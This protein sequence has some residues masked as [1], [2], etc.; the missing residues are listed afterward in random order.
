[1]NITPTVYTLSIGINYSP[2]SGFPTPTV[3]NLGP[4]CGNDADL[5]EKRIQSLFNVEKSVKLRNEQATKVNIQNALI[6]LKNDANQGVYSL[7]FFYYSGHGHYKPDTNSDEINDTN[8]EVII[9]FDF[10]N[11]N[12]STSIDDD[13]IRT[14]FTSQLSNNVC[15]FVFM[16][17]CHSGTIFDL[18]KSY[19]MKRTFTSS[20]AYTT[21]LYQYTNSNYANLNCNVFCISSS[22]DS[23]FSSVLPSRVPFSTQLGSVNQGGNVIIYNSTLN[24]YFAGGQDKPFAFS[25][26]SGKTWTTRVFSNMN[27]V[28]TI[29]TTGEVD[30]LLL[31][32]G[33]SGRYGFS[34]DNGN[35]FT[36]PTLSN[37]PLT[38]RCSLA[39]SNNRFFVGG[40]GRISFR[41]TAGV[42]TGHTSYFT[43]CSGMCFF[44]NNTRI[45]AVG[46]G[47]TVI[48]TN[49][50]DNGNG[51]KSTGSIAI[52]DL[53]NID[54]PTLQ[55]YSITN[56]NNFPYYVSSLYGVTSIGT[57]SLI[58]VGDTTSTP[59]KGIVIISTDDGESWNKCAEFTSFLPT[60]AH[61]TNNKC[62]I[63]GIGGLA[64]NTNVGNYYSWTFVNHTGYN[65]NCIANNLIVGRHPESKNTVWDLNIDGSL[66]PHGNS[67]LTEALFKE[68]PNIW[69]EN[70]Y[71]NQL[72]NQLTTFT[73]LLQTNMDGIDL[74]MN[75]ARDAIFVNLTESQ[76]IER[77]KS[78]DQT[79]VVSA[80]FTD[81]QLIQEFLDYFD[82]SIRT[83]F[84]GDSGLSKGLT[85]TPP[86]TFAPENNNSS[87]AP[88]VK[89][90]VPTKIDAMQQNFTGLVHF[91]INKMKH[92]LDSSI[93]NAKQKIQNAISSNIVNS[94][95]AATLN[96]Q[97]LIDTES[98]KSL[99]GLNSYTNVQLSNYANYIDQTLAT[100]ANKNTINA[101]DEFVKV[102]NSA[103]EFTST[104]NNALLSYTPSETINRILTVNNKY[105]LWN[106]FVTTTKISNLGYYNYTV[107]RTNNNDIYFIL[108]ESKRYRIV[109]RTGQDLVKTNIY[110]NG[111]VN[112]LDDLIIG[113][114]PVTDITDYFTL[115]R[116]LPFIP[117][118]GS[119][120]TIGTSSPFNNIF[121]ETA[122]NI[123]FF[124]T[125][126]ETGLNLKRILQSEEILFQGLFENLD[127]NKIVNAN[128]NITTISLSSLENKRLF[129]NIQFV[130]DSKLIRPSFVNHVFYMNS[131]GN[132]LVQDKTG[133]ET[134]RQLFNLDG[135]IYE[136]IINTQ[137][138]TNPFNS[139]SLNNAGF[140]VNT[141]NVQDV[142][143]YSLLE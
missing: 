71:T 89:F 110:E 93:E 80:S 87:N 53:T 70:L 63:C 92:S 47:S 83:D 26:D 111:Y 81:N 57:S 40:S 94:R 27:T 91:E 56:K 67:L 82:A 107:L 103:M 113:N 73:P 54:N 119:F 136:N 3:G 46:R 52:I 5:F 1:M 58:A 23:Q 36:F 85:T 130:Q 41:N 7:V 118:L 137:L 108:K 16:D 60:F 75:K 51:Q 127:N 121:Y 4:A 88:L 24:R 25:D 105:N 133:S 132:V 99:T 12:I 109:N 117:V 142:Q 78:M 95:N 6:Q 141:D 49:I 21:D 48:Q 10:L 32:A 17:N 126:T 114:E 138:F 18:K 140:F 44:K 120:I 74:P 139:L 20:S 29:A 96:L 19:E 62:F 134:K 9:P 143:G 84:T 66:L 11:S 28:N 97:S 100:K 43:N 45:C 42:W 14:N 79:V 31:I 125:C 61:F 35:T 77:L 33:P 65:L 22:L 128:D 2:V 90:K 135:T 59:K 102:M 39:L 64:F 122:N 104:E 116:Y 115:N 129:S 98:A 123:Y 106:E 15:L 34:S 101:L 37:V 8:D 76:K 30:S 38:P 13:W 68:N 131:Q 124:V 86:P 112:L 50:I 55:T 72:Q 69:F